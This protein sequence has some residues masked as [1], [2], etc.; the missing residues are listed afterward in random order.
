ML[1]AGGR[2]MYGKDVEGVKRFPDSPPPG[3]R[4]ASR[5]Y[6]REAGLEMY[7]GTFRLSLN[8]TL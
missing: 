6:K 5:A 2:C 7:L 3:A 8:T 4:Q 1:I